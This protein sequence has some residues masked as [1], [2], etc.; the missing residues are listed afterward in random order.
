[1]SGRSRSYR[2]LVIVTDT[3][4]YSSRSSVLQH[5]AQA[6]FDEALTAAARVAD[7]DR[8]AW[9]RQPSGDGELAVLPPEVDEPLLLSAFLPAIDTHLRRYNAYR[10]TEA[11]I[12]IR[13]ALHQGLL[14]V[15]SRNGFAGEAVNT[16][17]R[18]VDA[19]PLKAAFRAFPAANVACIVSDGI[20]RD[21]VCGG[22]EG[23]RRDRYSKIK[24]E[25]PDKDFAED[26]W[27]SILS[28][29]VTTIGLDPPRAGSPEPSPTGPAGS[30]VST[31]NI[32]NNGGQVAVGHQAQAYGAPPRSGR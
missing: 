16:T 4:R 31:G 2:R 18:L 10:V 29:D 3:E 20:Y 7:V 17:A 6:A 22:Y 30:G 13:V 11:R 23:I 1:M 19:P 26:A 14:F 32:D 25:L 28:E 9:Q 15:D 8:P 24:V 27:I 21:I 5:E 12:R